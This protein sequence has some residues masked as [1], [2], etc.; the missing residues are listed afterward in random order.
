VS[1]EPASASRTVRVERWQ[2]AA[3]RLAAYAGAAL[4][5]LLLGTAS[6]VAAAGDAASASVGPAVLTVFN[7]EIVTFRVTLY[8]YSPP[9]RVAVSRQRIEFLLERGGPGK[10]SVQ[11]AADGKQVLLDGAGVFFVAPGD[12][13]PLAEETLDATAASAA[14]ALEAAIQQAREQRS[15]Q[16]MLKAG[17]MALAATLA[18]AVALRLLFSLRRRLGARLASVIRE[19][20]ERV[21]VHGVSV[22]H[23]EV[24]GGAVSRTMTLLSWTAALLLSY[25]WLAFVLHR[26]PYT[27]PWGERLGTYLLELLQ[28]VATAVVTSVPGLLLVAF[29]FVAARFASQLLHLFFQRVESG[30]LELR[31]LDAE[32]A[33]PTRR[34]ATILLWLFALSMAYPYLPGAHTDAF[35]GLSVLVGLMISLGGAS[36]V[37]QA[38]SGLSLMY[39]RA[40]RPGEYVRVGEVEGTVVSLGFMRTIVQTGQGE[41]VSLPN[42]SIVA[43]SVHNFSRLAGGHGFVLQTGV[44]IGY[45]TP[46]RQVHAMLLEAARRTA[47]VR[48]EPPPY[49]VQTALSDFYI[50]YRLVAWAAPSEPQPRARV[51]NDLHANIQDVFNEHGVQIMSPHYMM[52][53]AQ[54]QVVPKE[55]WY[56][57]PAQPPGN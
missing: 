16:L 36:M 27:R 32:T 41:E 44:T 31:W 3:S 55:K 26:F 42:S 30:Q 43:A 4:F 46:W 28:T 25:L 9:E 11:D 50:E 18:Y 52:D 14:S 10:T 29:I 1:R 39:Q 34:I 12:V 7:R 38:L 37:G 47:G 21:R 23:P 48:P 20:A 17:A 40:L 6:S 8:G 51:M 24:L 49:V 54:L 15:V 2:A 5:F 19:R 53:P 35:K 13:N 33:V 57:P 56:A 45:S 22:L